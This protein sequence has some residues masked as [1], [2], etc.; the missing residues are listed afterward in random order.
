[1]TLRWNTG[2]AL[3]IIAVLALGQAGCATTPG[4]QTSSDSEQMSRTQKGALIGGLG[5]ALVGGLIGS[6][7]ANAGKGALIGGVVG[8]ATGGI[9]GN[10]MDKQAQELEQLAE[11]KRV[12]DG[13]VAT[14]K[15]KILFDFN[16]ST[17]KPESKASL[18]KMADILKKYDKTEITVA[19]YTDNVG[20]MSYNQQLSERRANAV[21][22][23]LNEQGVKAS[24]MTVMGFGPDNPIAS[25]DT[26]DGRAQNRRVELHISPNDQLLKDAK[27]QG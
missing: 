5:G 23:Y 20:T 3:T 6:K 10:Y 1:M 22:A 9:I 14:M 21:R 13:I 25:N 26:A 7:K 17:L 11:V 4:S 27:S 2:I 15:D 8:A 16:Q 18:Q 12:D 19:G 24:R